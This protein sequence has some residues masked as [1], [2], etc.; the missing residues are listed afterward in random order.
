MQFEINSSHKY[1]T[2]PKMV[3]VSCSRRT[4]GDWCLPS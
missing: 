4:N 2:D 1:A 3:A